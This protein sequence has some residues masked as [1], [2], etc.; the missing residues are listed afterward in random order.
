MSGINFVQNNFPVRSKVVDYSKTDSSPIPLIREV[1]KR[2][3]TPNGFETANILTG[4]FIFQ[5]LEGDTS[6][7]FL[8]DDF[9]AA[10]KISNRLDFTPGVGNFKPFLAIVNIPQITMVETPKQIDLANPDFNRRIRNI[11]TTIGV[12]KKYNYVGHEF[13][14][15][16]YGDPVQVTFSDMDD[17]RDPIFIG[18]LNTGIVNNMGT[19]NMNNSGPSNYVNDCSGKPNVRTNIRRGTAAP[20]SI[21]TST[22]KIDKFITSLDQVDIKKGTSPLGSPNKG[23]S[24]NSIPYQIAIPKNINKSK[25]VTVFLMFHGDGSGYNASIKNLITMG[26]SHIPDGYNIVLLRPFLA[27][28]PSKNKSRT[29]QA[30]FVTGVLVSHGLAPGD[31]V[32]F[33]HSGGGSAHGWYL[34]QLV[35]QGTFESKISAARFLDSDY[36]W[37]SVTKLFE[38]GGFNQSKITF[39]TEA[40][41]KPDQIATGKFNKDRYNSVYKTGARVI[42]TNIPHGECAHQIGPEYLIP[43]VVEVI[44]PAPPKNPAKKAASKTVESKKPTSTEPEDPK[45]AKLKQDIQTDKSIVVNYRKN[46]DIILSKYPNNTLDQGTIQSLAGTPAFFTAFADRKKINK[47]DESIKR[48][49]K[50]IITKEINLEALMGN[51][52]DQEKIQ[53]ALEAGNTPPKPDDKKVNSVTPSTNRPAQSK[54]VDEEKSTCSYGNYNYSGATPED[55]KWVKYSSGYNNRVWQLPN[56]KSYGYGTLKMERYLK[57]LANVPGGEDIGKGYKNNPA[58]SKKITDTNRQPP[59]WLKPGWWFGHISIKRG[60]DNAGHITHEAGIGIDLTFPT[61]YTDANGKRFRGVNLGEYTYRGKT[62]TSMLGAKNGSPLLWNRDIDQFAF[63][64]YLRYSIPFCSSIIFARPWVRP[65]KKLIEEFSAQSKNGWSLTHPAYVDFKN[66]KCRLSGDNHT[67]SNHFHIRLR[68]P[69][70]A[71]GPFKGTYAPAGGPGFDKK[72]KNGRIDEGTP[73]Y[74]PYEQQKGLYT[75]K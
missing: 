13:A 22:E 46:K 70:I 66:R 54:K 6:T 29:V 18:P 71:P 50:K 16:N 11:I 17:F 38:T 20:K 74:V 25:P 33:S 8:F 48:V 14:L 59:T 60:G 56:C 40:G 51:A 1:V 65:V 62:G 32:S 67:H 44:G 10:A 4:D 2:A 31:I 15:P 26:P 61:I 75:P 27:K 57:G 39:L 7:S 49:Q 24:A 5:V 28:T 63:M 42:R 69:G 41:K 37:N 43:K 53:K 19:S 21:I 52:G 23:A 58:I 30:G 73:G 3:N 9:L 64:E 68:L 55:L 47:L 35:D 72:R 34:K 45:I 36:G 12:F